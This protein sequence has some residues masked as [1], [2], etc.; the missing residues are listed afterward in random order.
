VRRALVR[1]GASLAIIFIVEAALAIASATTRDVFRLWIGV[2]SLLILTAAVL[3]QF[4]GPAGRMSNLQIRNYMVSSGIKPLW[5]M[6]RPLPYK[7]IGGAFA[8]AF[9]TGL[10]LGGAFLLMLFLV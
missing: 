9:G 5:D 4:A 3:V 8:V 7:R 1:I 6:S 2:T 10:V